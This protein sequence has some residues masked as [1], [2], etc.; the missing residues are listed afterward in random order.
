MVGQMYLT[1]LKEEKRDN[2]RILSQW[3]CNKK[4]ELIS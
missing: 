2:G 1:D 4:F 3:R